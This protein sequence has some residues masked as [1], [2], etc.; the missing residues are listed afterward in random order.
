MKLRLLEKRRKA[1]HWLPGDKLKGLEVFKR[2]WLFSFFSLLFPVLPGLVWSQDA[3]QNLTLTVAGQAIQIPIVQTKGK[4]YVD[5]NAL[6]R[7]TNSS[8][9]FKGNQ[10]ILTPPD[11]SLRTP[12]AAPEASATAGQQKLVAAKGQ[13]ADPEPADAPHQAK[14]ADPSEQAKAGA[15][16]DT[17]VAPEGTQVA[18]EETPA[19]AANA[20]AL[21]KAAQNPV[22]SLI[23]VPIQNNANAGIMPGNRTQDVVNIQPVIPLKINNDWNLI[24]RVI[25]PLIYQPFP[26]PSPAPQVGVFGLGDIQPTALLSPRKPHKIIWGVGPIFQ[27]PTATSHYTGQGKL[28]MGPNVVALAMP[29]NFVLGVLVNNLWSVAGSGS[30]PDVNQLL[31]QYFVNYNMKKGW[32]LTTQPIL[33]ANWNSAAA[34]GSVW[35]LP[36]GGGVGRIMKLG[37]QPVNI[38]VQAYG[39]AV[40]VPGDSPWTVRATFALLFPKLTPAQEKMM[41]EQKL[42]QLEQTPP[43]KN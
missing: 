18:T 26:A 40:H 10:V 5:I 12:P 25:T 6:A 19:A 2:F 43:A 32:Y 24:V 27:L 9:S 4:S 14:P 33:T 16:Q 29:R 39:N 15:S 23:S 17:P 31:L 1:H 36:F 35:T 8:L 30:R 21:R 37:F 41:M 7:L 11:S 42:K 22:A 3:Q 38:N 13:P 20:D 28:A 34:S